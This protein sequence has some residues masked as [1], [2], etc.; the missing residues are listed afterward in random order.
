MEEASTPEKRTPPD[1]ARVAAR[2]AAFAAVTTRGLIEANYNGERKAK[3][4][5]RQP[6]E[7]VD[8]V[9]IAGE[10][11]QGE[12]L[13][14]RTAIGQLDRQAVVDAK[15]RCE[16]MVVLAWCLG[17]LQLPRYDE[18]YGSLQV[19]EALGFPRER[20]AT[21][22]AAPSLR[23]HPEIQHGANTYLTV[24]WRLRQY[25]VDPDPIDFANYVSHCTWGPLTL[26]DVSLIDGDLAIR[27]ERIDRIPEDWYYRALSI[28]RERHKAFNWLL[29]FD[30]VYSWVEA[31]T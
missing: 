28:A 18:Q 16:A 29:G 10:L 6:C 22:L 30:P 21:V 13:L 8:H 17:R 3:D 26:S 4:I 1:A 19:A 15:W 24:D 9:G 11:E 27:G 25:S 31:P 14:I 12:D 23:P 20:S 7:W 5:W 2:A